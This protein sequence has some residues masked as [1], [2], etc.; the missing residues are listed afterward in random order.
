MDEKLNTPTF[1]FPK[2]TAEWPDIQTDRIEYTDPFKE[3]GNPIDE[4]WLR[5]ATIAEGRKY[6][7][8]Y[9]IVSGM[10]CIISEDEQTKWLRWRL[11]DWVATHIKNHPLVGRDS[12]GHELRAGDKAKLIVFDGDSYDVEI[13]QHEGILQLYHPSQGYYPLN[14]AL[15]R[16]DMHLEKI[17]EKTSKP[18]NHVE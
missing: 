5:I 12:E 1:A 11:R 8:E 4:I 14:T 2:V 17:Q 13:V 6:A 7:V 18:K 10:D 9:K 15:L 3:G 16:Q